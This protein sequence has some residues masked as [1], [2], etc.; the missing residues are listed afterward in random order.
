[1]IFTGVL[2]NAVL[3][4]I[5]TMIGLIFKGERLKNIGQRIFEAFALFVPSGRFPAGDRAPARGAP[6]PV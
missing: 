4:I 1:M 5:G 2:I 3:V 6:V